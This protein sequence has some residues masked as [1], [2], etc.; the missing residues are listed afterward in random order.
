MGR[1]SVNDQGQVQAP[2]EPKKILITDSN[3]TAGV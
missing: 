3:D 2:Y 1:I